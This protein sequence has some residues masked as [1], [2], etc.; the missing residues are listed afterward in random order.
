MRALFIYISFFMA[1]GSG[2]EGSL[3]MA[4]QK[5]ADGDYGASIQYYLQALKDYPQRAAEIR[6]NIGQCYWEMD[7]MERAIQ[8]YHQ[9]MNQVDYS[10]S[11]KASNNIGTLLVKRQNPR[12][13]LETFKEALIQ[14]PD[15]E[16]ARYN[17]ELLKK[18]L[19]GN[20]K[21]NPPKAP[22][23]PPPPSNSEDEDEEIP[24]ANNGP[25]KELPEA[26]KD[27]I[28]QLMQKQRQSQSNTDKGK[29]VGNDTISVVQARRLLEA[30]RRNEIQFLQQLRKSAIVPNSKKERP[31]W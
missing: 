16:V 14:D 26:Y 7:S 18:Q 11:S 6:F 30:M 17:Y 8:Y 9:A 1:I 13:A 10:I 29:P 19:R 15:N 22:N 3:T 20:Q 28:R 31:D 2:G 27:L 4:N 24:E 23:N 12:E 5:F 21:N 25:S